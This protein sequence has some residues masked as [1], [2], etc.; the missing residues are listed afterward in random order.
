MH[1]QQHFFGRSGDLIGDK[2]TYSLHKTLLI[3]LFDSTY[4]LPRFLA[5]SFGYLLH[6]LFTLTLI[7]SVPLLANMPLALP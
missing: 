7:W 2:M 6:E 3:A 5:P 4:Q 1:K